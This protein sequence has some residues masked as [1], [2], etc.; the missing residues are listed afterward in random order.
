MLAL[1]SSTN[2]TRMFTPFDFLTSAQHIALQSC[3]SGLALEKTA[4]SGYLS[5]KNEIFQS[6]EAS[7]RSWP[8]P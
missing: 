8:I 1:N 4:L 3:S 2:E 5:G 6:R 7:T